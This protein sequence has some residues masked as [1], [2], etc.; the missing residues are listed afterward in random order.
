MQNQPQSKTTM[1]VLCFLCGALG[2]HR[3]L[4][5]YDKW[6]LMIVV[7]IVTLGFGGGLWALIDFIRILTGSLKMATGEA[8]R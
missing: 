5:G 2:I 4:M 8:L 3:K 6:W 7:T 1:A